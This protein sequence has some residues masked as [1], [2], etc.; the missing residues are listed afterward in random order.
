MF[1]QAPTLRRTMRLWH[2]FSRESYRRVSEQACYGKHSGS[3]TYHVI[4]IVT[5]EHSSWEFVI[6]ERPEE[7]TNQPV[8]DGI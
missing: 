1:A 6:R 5:D 8:S 4:S 3:C 2:W 7:R